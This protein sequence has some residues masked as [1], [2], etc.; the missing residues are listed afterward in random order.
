MMNNELMPV[1]EAC[2]PNDGRPHGIVDGHHRPEVCCAETTPRLEP[3]LMMESR[4]HK[5]AEAAAEAIGR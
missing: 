4:W 3:R 1:V 2:V 5:E